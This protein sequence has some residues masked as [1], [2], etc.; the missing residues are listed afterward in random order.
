MSLYK[1]I[2]AESL[3][4]YGQDP[5]SKTGIFRA[6][7]LQTLINNVWF[8]NKEDEGII[9]PEFSE[10]NTLSMATMDFVLMVVSP[11]LQ[12]RIQVVYKTLNGANK[13]FRL[14]TTWTNGS[15]VIM[16]TSLLLLQHT[17]QNIM[18]TS[19][20]SWISRRKH[21][22]QTSSLICSGIY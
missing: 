22:R 9:H 2:A 18:P 17:R 19:S 4:L 6:P 5:V 12:N 10:N 11:V 15:L 20:L 14:K 21:V 3:H 13:P 1:N 16:S 8:K 7:L